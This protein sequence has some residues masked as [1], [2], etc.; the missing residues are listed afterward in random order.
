[1]D[2]YYVNK[3]AQ[4]DSGGQKTLSND[5]RWLLFLF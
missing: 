2:A 1:M 3:N 5:S 4:P